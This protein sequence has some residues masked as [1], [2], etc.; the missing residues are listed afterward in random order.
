MI[1]LIKF[2]AGINA[3][4][5]SRPIYKLGQ[6]GR[7]GQC[8]CIGLIIG[9]I[10]RAGGEWKGTH[11]SNYAA[12]NE[13]QTLESPPRLEVGAAV[14][15]YHEPGEA[16]WNLPAAYANHPDQ[17]DYYHV[18]VVISVSPLKIAHCTS[19]SGGSGIKIDTVIGKWRRGGRL[20]KVGYAD[21]PEPGE[22]PK[23]GDDTVIGYINLPATSNVFHRISPN[24]SSAWFG[25]INGGEAVDVVSINNGWARVRWGGHDGYVM[26]KFVTTDAQPDPM[27]PDVVDVD[28]VALLTELEGLNRRQSAIITAL[29]GVM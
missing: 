6:D 17:R 21:A 29:R 5:D 7:N 3:I 27:P 2:L 25:R 26:S 8:D 22:P 13:M 12:R 11:G 9:A 19:W 16:G 4:I 28:K 14:Y 1:T 23:E 15:K 24:K 20:K 10:R 18:G